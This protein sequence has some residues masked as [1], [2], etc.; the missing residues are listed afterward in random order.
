M[1]HD[2]LTEMIRRYTINAYKIDAL[3]AK[4]AKNRGYNESDLCL[5][6]ALYP[7]YKLSQRQICLEWGLPKSTLNTTLKR[8][9]AQGYLCLSKKENNNKELIVELTDK[10]RD[11]VK[12][13]IESLI[14]HEREVM[15]KMLNEYG[16]IFVDMQ[17]VFAGLLN[18]VLK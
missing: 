8:F 4:Y 6:Y 10:G 11:N 3:Y 2:R 18:E 7:N 14:M 1:V 12:D 9:E 15:Q 17:S 5:F 13:L 16:E